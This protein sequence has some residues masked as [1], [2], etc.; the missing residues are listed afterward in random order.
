MSAAEESNAVTHFPGNS[1]AM[2]VNDVK[3]AQE[4]AV[5]RSVFSLDMRIHIC[6]FMGTDSYSYIYV[7]LW[8]VKCVR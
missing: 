7:H 6:T 3:K 8:E 1:S 2:P 4:S 5:D